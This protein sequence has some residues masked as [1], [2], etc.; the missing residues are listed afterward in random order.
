MHEDIEKLLVL[1]E[2][3]RSI[4]HAKREVT[5]LEHER[6]EVNGRSANAEEA[7]A[8]AGQKAMELDFD[9]GKLMTAVVW[10]PN[11]EQCPVT[12]FVDGNG[13]WVWYNEDGTEGGRSTFKGGV[14]VRD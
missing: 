5:G 4:S 6:T 13:V 14:E 11:G 8:A 3:D 9:E 2:R 10:K 7:K 1:Q 12:N